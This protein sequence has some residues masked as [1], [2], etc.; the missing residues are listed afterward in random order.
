MMLRGLPV[1]IP[2]H[3]PDEYTEID[4]RERALA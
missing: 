4:Q 2:R 3:G 1:D